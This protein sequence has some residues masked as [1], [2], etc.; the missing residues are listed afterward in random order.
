MSGI[1]VVRALRRSG[2]GVPV[3]MLTARDMPADRVLG[4]DEGADDY[5]VKPFHFPELLGPAA[6]LATQAV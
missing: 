3:L 6:R 5:M 1:E 4:L 2:S